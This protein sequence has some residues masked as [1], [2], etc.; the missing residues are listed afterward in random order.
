MK[1]QVNRTGLEFIKT[2]Q[3]FFTDIGFEVVN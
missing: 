2:T 1:M 3:A